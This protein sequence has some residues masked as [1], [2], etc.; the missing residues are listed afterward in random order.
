MFRSGAGRWCV[1]MA[2][3]LIQVALHK[4]ALLWNA[5]DEQCVGALRV[6]FDRAVPRHCADT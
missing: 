2:C 6:S 1:A 5:L 3:R 4:I